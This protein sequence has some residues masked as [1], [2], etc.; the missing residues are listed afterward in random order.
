VLDQSGSDV[1]GRARVLFSLL[2]A[3]SLPVSSGLW[4]LVLDASPTGEARVPS[5]GTRNALRYAVRTRNRG[6]AAG[7]ALVVI[8]PDG[9]GA[10]NLPAVEQA[11]AALLAVGLEVEA[12][13]LALETA[14]AMGL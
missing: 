5:A 7:L 4:A 2:E 10:G 14:V 1:V 9:P 13:Q 12:R 3:L 8:G 11:I 6:A